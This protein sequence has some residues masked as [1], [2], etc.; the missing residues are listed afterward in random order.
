MLIL[1]IERVK[2]WILFLF[3]LLYV[4]LSALQHQ[5]EKEHK[6]LPSQDSY[7]TVLCSY[8]QAVSAELSDPQTSSLC[9][10]IY[11]KVYLWR[12]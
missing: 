8:G 5:D 9:A 3:F 11:F 12:Y 1:S 2:K 4:G 7:R 10:L 6:V